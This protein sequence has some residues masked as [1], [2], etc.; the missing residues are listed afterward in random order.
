MKGCP[1]ARQP[2]IS[3]PQFDESEDGYLPFPADGFADFFA[4]FLAFFAMCFLP[5]RICP[6][7]GLPYT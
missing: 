7:A 1:C 6:G 2:F 3:M 4:G 5:L